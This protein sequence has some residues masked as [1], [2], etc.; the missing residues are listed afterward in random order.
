MPILDLDGLK[1]HVQRSGSGPDVVLVHGLTGD[2]SIWMLCK[3]MSV[4]SERFRV[5]AYDL[6]GHGYSD[7][8][9][10]GYTSADHAHDLLALMGTLEIESARVVGHSFGAVIAL[11]AAV[12]APDK[13]E[14]LVLSDPYFPALRH[15]E[16]ASR[17]D[18]WRSF[19][20]EAEDAGISLSDEHWY[21]LGRF[22]DQVVH[23]DSDR[24]LKLRRAVGLPG[25]NRLLR[26]GGTSCG[27]DS[28]L[29]S[30]LT[31]EA[32]RSV[33]P[34]RPRP[35]RREFTV[36]GDG[37]LSRIELAGLPGRIDTGGEAPG[38]GR[39]PG[40]VRPDRPRVPRRRR[41]DGGG[42]VKSS[43]TILLTG[44]ARGHRPCH[45][46]GARLARASAR[47]D[48]SGCNRT[49]CDRRGDRLPR[50]SRRRGRLLCGRPAQSRRWNARSVR[51][52]CSWPAL[53]VG[54]LSS[55]TDPRHE[56]PAIDAGSKRPRRGPRDRGGLAGDDGEAIGITSSRSPAWPVS[57]GCRGCRAIRR[58]RRRSRRTSKACVRH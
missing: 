49:H 42:L 8:P 16:D 54:S 1:I 38:S 44:A 39:E 7:A 36:P 17:W 4:L 27:D 53:G 13:I 3:A 10:T 2:L 47:P 11:H 40:G 14:S 28:K 6:R 33:S 43:K 5:T 24:M 34:T 52:R 48:R 56:G 41:V 31:S 35:L 21:D 12:L 15:L 57:V 9:P 46:E 37:R 50:R 20:K 51:S 18:H 22:F 19:H 26:L 30:G 29:D 23:L 25:L 58:R 32:I 55:A 45:G